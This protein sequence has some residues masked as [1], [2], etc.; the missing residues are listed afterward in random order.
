[1]EGSELSRVER[2]DPGTGGGRWSGT[3]WLQAADR[4][5]VPRPLEAEVVLGRA[6]WDSQAAGG[7]VVRW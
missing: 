5:R 1:M 7:A 2:R 6:R 3:W 4:G